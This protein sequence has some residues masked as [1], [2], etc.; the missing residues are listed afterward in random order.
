M[1]EQD[2]DFMLWQRA[3]ELL[4]QAERIRRNFLQIAAASHYRS[5]PARTA[6]WEPPVN[7]VDT[8]NSLWVVV[9]LAGVKADQ[10][11][12]RIDGSE[13]VIAGARPLPGCCAEGQLQLWEVPFGYFERRLRLVGAETLQLQAPVSCRDGLLVV[14]LRKRS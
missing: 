4:Q 14:E 10:I 7:V 6:C 2:W 13:L 3:H 5:T 11:D 12:V 9:A 1:S 8:A